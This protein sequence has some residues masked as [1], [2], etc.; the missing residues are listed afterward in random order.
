MIINALEKGLLLARLRSE[1]AFREH[2][3]ADAPDK[4]ADFAG[5]TYRQILDA[6]DIGAARFA[7]IVSDLHG[8]PRAKLEDLMAGGSLAERF[9][10]TFLA[11]AGLYPYAAEGGIR[12]AV[13]DPSAGDLIRTLILSLGDTVALEVASFEDV[14]IALNRTVTSET[15][16]T[17]PEGASD[18]DDVDGL[19][20]LAS[21]APVVRA[22]DE[23]FE[24][25][26]A[27]R[28]TDIH[29]EPARAQF[30]VRVRVDGVMQVIPPP[31]GIATRALVSR[32]KIVS[33]LNIAERRLPQDGRARIRV[34]SREF[35]VRVATMP[36]THGEAAILRLLDRAGRLT[37]FDQLGLSPRDTAVLRRN[38]AMP[39]GLIVVTGPTGSGKTTTLASALTILNDSSSKIL[40]I[41]DPVEYEVPGVS[42]SQVRVA[43]GLTFAT[44]LRAFL[45]QDPDVIMVGEMRDTETARICI[46]A[47]LTGHLVLSTLHTNSAASAIIR[48]VDMGVEPFLVASALRTIVAQRLVRVLCGDCRRQVSLAPSDLERNPRYAALGLAPGARVFEAGGC[49]RCGGTGYRG[50]RAIFEV[51][52]VTEP[53]RR[54]ILANASDADIEASACSS[55]MTSMIEDGVAKALEGLTTIDEVFRVAALR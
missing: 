38:L 5:R 34:R 1:G 52:E 30:Q 27:M 47:S 41:E 15:V 26:V 32:I 20:D 14:E 10:P 23:I 31:P 6:S 28:A 55:G 44:A 53:L 46:Q 36:T 8:L 9:S 3:R 2:D 24:R 43:V 16:A 54:L 42:Q 29:I 50:R 19:R 11:E 49:D 37:E 33:G 25:A 21:G 17:P 12:L 51:I 22:L 13:A 7:D 39:H 18:G 48:L 45:R 35:D 40:T 4:A